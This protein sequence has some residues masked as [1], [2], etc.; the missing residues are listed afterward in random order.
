MPMMRNIL[1]PCLLTLSVLV[2]AQ[3]QSYADCV[4]KINSTWGKQCDKCEAYKDGYKRDYSGVYQLELKNSCS[5]TVEVKVATQEKNGTWRTFPVKALT[6][7]ETMTAF[8]CQGTG[9]YMYWVRKLNDTEVVIPSD[10]EILVEY[11][12]R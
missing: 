8:A 3:D 7:G 11:R 1:L 12:G 6:T 2:N 4:V 9:K 10:Q 5:E